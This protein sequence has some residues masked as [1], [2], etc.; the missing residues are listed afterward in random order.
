MCIVHIGSELLLLA[1]GNTQVLVCISR[2]SVVGMLGSAMQPA[3]LGY[4][5]AIM[6]RPCSS[7]I[8]TCLWSIDVAFDN[9]LVYRPGFLG[10]PVLLC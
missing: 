2:I 4:D 1:V 9:S 7:T 6:Q 3:H 8:V 10:I 5:G